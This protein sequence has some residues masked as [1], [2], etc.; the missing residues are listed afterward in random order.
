MNSFRS[1]LFVCKS[2]VNIMIFFKMSDKTKLCRFCNELLKLNVTFYL[3]RS[4][5][6]RKEV[7][8][9][10]DNVFVHETLV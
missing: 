8:N 2:Q 5:A 1:R 9:D 7:T 4:L 10:N 3:K 6:E